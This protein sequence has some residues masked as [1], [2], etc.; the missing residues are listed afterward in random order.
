MNDPDALI[1]QV[2]AEP[3]EQPPQLVLWT[4][5]VRAV[6]LDLDIDDIEIQATGSGPDGGKF[7]GL[8]ETLV[9]KLGIVALGTAV[10]KIREWAG[11]SGRTVKITIDGDS[12]ELTGVSTA[13]QQQ[14][15]DI[16]L[17]KHDPSRP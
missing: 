9:V 13:T 3:G 17:A 1:V 6:L 12:I 7:A 11:R 5:Q 10:A 8:A 15:L 14:L 16:W 2:A 4:G